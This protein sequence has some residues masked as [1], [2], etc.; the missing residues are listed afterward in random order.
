MDV[1]PH[2]AH[3]IE[4]L[5]NGAF[6]NTE[7]FGDFFGGARTVLSNELIEAFDSVVTVSECHTKRCLKMSV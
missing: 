6:M 1:G 4:F 3:D 5:E 7:M 2:C